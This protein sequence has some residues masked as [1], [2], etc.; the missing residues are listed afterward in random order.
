[1]ELDTLDSLDAQE[2]LEA[3]V[4]KAQVSLER[5]DVLDLKEPPDPHCKLIELGRS[6]PH[7]C[8]ISFSLL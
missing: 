8:Q 4:L 5:L 3:L 2:T 1:M 6:I 7:L